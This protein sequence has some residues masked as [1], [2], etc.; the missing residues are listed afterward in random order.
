MLNNFYTIVIFLIVRTDL[1]TIY[2]IFIF[3]LGF[4]LDNKGIS[5]QGLVVRTYFQNFNIY[6]YHM[7]QY[8]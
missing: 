8:D 2:N 4:L 3:T 1:I 5:N 7:W 6:Y